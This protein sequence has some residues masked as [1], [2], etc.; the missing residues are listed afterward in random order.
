MCLSYSPSEY[1]CL[2]EARISTGSLQVHGAYLDVSLCLCLLPKRDKLSN[3]SKGHI[4]VG[5]SES[6]CPLWLPTVSKLYSGSSGIQGQIS[7]AFILKAVGSHLM[8]LV[9]DDPIHIAKEFF[10][11]LGEQL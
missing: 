2:K 11:K 5:L 6:P 4:G 8:C 3:S 10:W 1:G 7:R 9:K